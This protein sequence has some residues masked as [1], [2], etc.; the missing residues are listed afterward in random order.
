M[1][2]RIYAGGNFHKSPEGEHAHN[3]TTD[4]APQRETFLNIVV[5]IILGSSVTQ[6]NSLAL[7]VKFFDKD[8]QLI[9]DRNNF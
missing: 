2:K 1:A 8:I 3:N 4:N 9:A 7:T 5:G 6:R